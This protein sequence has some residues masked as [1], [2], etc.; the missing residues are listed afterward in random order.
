MANAPSR[1][2]HQALY[3]LTDCVTGVAYVCIFGWL[4]AFGRLA[5]YLLQM[6]PPS[7]D[8]LLFGNFLFFI[9]LPL[10]A[11]LVL[12]AVLRRGKYR[13][14]TIVAACLLCIA[15][16]GYVDPTQVLYQKQEEARIAGLHRVAATSQPLIA[17]I[18]QYQSEHG[19]PPAKLEELVPAYLSD[20]PTTGILISPTF[21]YSTHHAQDNTKVWEMSVGCPRGVIDFSRYRYQNPQ[22]LELQ[23]HPAVVARDGNW[24]YEQD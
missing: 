20:I 2:H 18:E 19:E 15:L 22:S 7:P 13:R 3:E 17:A 6:Q 11:L 5:W 21:H 12:L 24:T 16:L 10:V 1:E 14:W 4:Y 23:Q 9:S 8:Y